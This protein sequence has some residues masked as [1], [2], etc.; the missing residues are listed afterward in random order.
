MILVIAILTT[1]ISVSI[2][3]ITPTRII[4]MTI[5][6]SSNTS[7]NSNSDEDV[8]FHSS[9]ALVLVWDPLCFLGLRVKVL[10]L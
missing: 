3:V 2:T 6:N 7:N 10:G 4:A 9:V 1:V 5:N 8:P